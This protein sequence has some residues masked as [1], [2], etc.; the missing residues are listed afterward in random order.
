MAALGGIF[1]RRT[2]KEIAERHASSLARIR[3]LLNFK[4]KWEFFEGI[5]QFLT[6]FLSLKTV[7]D[8]AI[9]ALA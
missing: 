4:K 3:F 9:R 6:P 2:P 5:P 8:P 1:G 7:S